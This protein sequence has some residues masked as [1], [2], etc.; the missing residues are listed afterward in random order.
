MD[1]PEL[2]DQLANYLDIAELASAA[3]VCKSWNAT[4]TPFLYR[5]VEWSNATL[6]P[7]TEAL[8]KNGEYVKR[9]YAFK[10]P[11]GLPFE[12]FIHLEEL[13]L[14]LFEYSQETWRQ[15]SNVF[16][17]FSRVERVE[18]YTT[19]TTEMPIEFTTNLLSCPSVKNL[20]VSFAKFG[21]KATEQLLDACVRLEQLTLNADDV[22]HLRSFDQWEVFP[23]MHSLH[24]SLNLGMTM[25]HQLQWIK[26]CPRLE[27]L[28]WTANG[29]D[30]FP[31]SEFC[32]TLSTACP[33]IK[34]LSL[35]ETLLPDR[36][37]SQIIS[38][39]ARLTTL[40]VFESG[41]GP[42]SFQSCSSHFAFLTQLD[43]RRCQHSTSAMSQGIMTSCPNLT[44]FCASFLDARD[45]LGIVE[46]IQ[47]AEET[48]QPT[49]MAMT[50]TVAHSQDWVCLNLRSLTL[51]LCGLEGKPSEWQHQVLR[52]LGRLE[53]L[54]FLTIGPYDFHMD[55]TRDGID[56]R[57]EAGLGILGNLKLLERFCFDGLHQEMSENDLLWMLEAWPELMRVEGKVHYLLNR[58]LELQTILT[59]AFIAMIGYLDDEN[60]DE[61]LSGGDGGEGEIEETE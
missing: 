2:R 31:V 37:V 45:I 47:S 42:I 9:T 48:A 3:A 52:Q 40:K 26:R 11:F 10:E 58:R 29:S 34:D 61:A 7:S 14:R 30:A 36:D 43:I 33:L 23:A 39:C 27:S 24:L 51:F 21:E 56:L 38:S 60:L 25:Y 6:T 35:D 32:E 17:Q 22:T 46:V 44:Y 55:G 15:L 5:V 41:F 13:H 16:S 49:D 54:D 50:T 20:A 28:S 18:I 53:K 57:L 8:E 19:S 12:S 59:D 1:L 4:F